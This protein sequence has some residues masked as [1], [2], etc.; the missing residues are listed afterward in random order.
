MI[1]RCDQCGA[2]LY[3]ATY[4]T[5]SFSMADSFCSDNCIKEFLFKEHMDNLR[6]LPL[7]RE[8]FSSDYEYNAMVAYRNCAARCGLCRE[9]NTETYLFCQKFRTKLGASIKNFTKE[10]YAELIEK[11]ESVLN[12][13]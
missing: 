10:S 1:P 6:S 2:P 4:K 3:K 12:G 9:Y 13:E 11:N 8:D 7:T 5:V